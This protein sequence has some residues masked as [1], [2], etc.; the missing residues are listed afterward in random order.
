LRRRLGA[1]GREF[2]L[3]NATADRMV[4]KTLMVYEELRRGKSAA[5]PAGQ[6]LQA[7][8]DSEFSAGR[9]QR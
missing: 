6:G 9:G 3:A 4:S 1:S 7:Q 8:A 2:V 5:P